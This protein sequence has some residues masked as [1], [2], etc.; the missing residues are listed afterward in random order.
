MNTP[1][2]PT[3]RAKIFRA[4]TI[5][6]ACLM[7]AALIGLHR[8]SPVS[9]PFADGAVFAPEGWELS[10][11]TSAEGRD[12]AALPARIRVPQGGSATL[13]TVLCGR[14]TDGAVLFFRSADSTVSVSVDGEEIYAMGHG[15]KYA[16]RVWH[17]I[18]LPQNSAGRTLSI[19]QNQVLRDFSAYPMTFSEVYIASSPAAVFEFLNRSH[20][21]FFYGSTVLGLVSLA[22]LFAAVFEIR[23]NAR[24]RTL[25]YLSAAF[26]LIAVW[27]L[28]DSPL[29]Q[30]YFSA[31][32]WHKPYL[33][34][35]ISYLVGLL[36]TVPYLLYVGEHYKWKKLLER[37]AAVTVAAAIILCVLDL[38]SVYTIVES[39]PAILI[40][41]TFNIL[42]ILAVSAADYLPGNRKQKKLVLAG[43]ITI[44]LF[45]TVEFIKFFLL[46]QESTYTL[47]YA[48]M[49]FVLF[50]RICEAVS[51]Y[52]K[53][54]DEHRLTQLRNAEI[55]RTVEIRQNHYRQLA[56]Q[57][58]LNRR[59]NH[60]LKHFRTMLYGAILQNAPEKTKNLLE[61]FDSVY[62]DMQVQI[63]CDNMELNA[64]I[65]YAAMNCEKNGVAFI[66]AVN[67]GET[68]PVDVHDFCVIAGN[69]LDNA[70][71]AAA[72]RGAG[73]TVEIKAAVHN[74]NLVLMVENTYTGEPVLRGGAFVSTKE[75]P[76]Q[77][78]LGISIVRR[79]AETTGGEL[80]LKA[81]DG[82]FTASVIWEV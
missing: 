76:E 66:C 40:L 47:L 16:G 53:T 33:L 78:G 32:Y 35:Y 72:K 77:H 50:A 36:F 41:R 3:T 82:V 37:L 21:F 55:M 65:S 17:F 79:L 25:L 24:V 22:L 81:E 10:S 49:A 62:N 7:L 38:L 57:I 60:D 29:T 54:R 39:F 18:T 43:D 15:S 74:S 64:I 28:S 73:G 68:L 71:D 45:G 2:N 27:S 11:G 63:Y 31:L 46:G 14:V 56:G 42:V 34:T 48:G 75:N 26:I 9:V 69:L 51:G 67:L 8:A 12:A 13:S 44:C 6:L 19:T 5:I 61:Q 58:E 59:I 70:A 52:L 4:M 30:L 20:L 1:S 23:K 80:S